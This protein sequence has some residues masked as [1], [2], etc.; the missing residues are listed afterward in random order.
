MAFHPS[1]I[2]RRNFVQRAGLLV[3]ALGLSGTV[4]S[5]IMDSITK[6]AARK[7]GSEA[8][9]QSASRAKFFVEICF[10]A[11]F[12][13]NSLFPS[14]GH[15]ATAGARS[16]RLNFYS[17]AAN[18]KSIDR[19]GR[20]V[21]I[22]TF[23]GLGGQG[24]DA[25]FNELNLRTDVGVATS[26]S[27]QLQTG[28]H[29][30]S[31]NSRGPTGSSAA[32]AIVHASIAA[33]RPV[34]GIEWNNGAAVT[35]E[36]G[37]SGL[38]ALSRVQNRTQFQSLFRELPMYFTKDELKLIV[39][40]F[41][42]EGKVMAGQE[43]ALQRIDQLWRSTQD[44][45]SGVY[46][47]ADAVVV[48]STAGRNQSTLSLLQAIDQRYTQVTGA[49][50]RFAAAGVLNNGLGGTNLAQ[51]LASAA[52]AFS[53]GASSTFTVACESGDWHGDINQL[54][55][56]GGKQGRWNLVLGN[57]LAGL[58]EAANALPDPDEPSKTVLDGL[59]ISLT[60][61][62]T[63]TPLRNGANSGDDNG[64]GGR[65]AFTYIGK[66]VRNGAYG[67]IDHTNGQVI[68]FNIT[69]GQV[70]GAAPTEM[71]MYRTSLKLIGA[72]SMAAGFGVTQMPVDA[73]IKP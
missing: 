61:E 11:G 21:F 8:L 15:A 68:G 4:Q 19:D 32:P 7:W 65:A 3:S 53:A 40:T 45:R 29:T 47:D 16:P 46:N 33:G 9:A 1:Q 60:S 44:P 30:G 25:L 12:Q 20:D 52:A 22:A 37:T 70:G 18:V 71:Q 56:Q 51:A 17:S 41:D 28:Q 24:G 27:V 31:F 36:R 55:D 67:N 38:P 43:G 34:Q 48:N 42:A 2:T 62:F 69:N 49:G 50:S 63:R 13:N 10:R 58:I 14:A 26:E 54:D 5:G 6:K 66:M 64:D 35:N 57:S 72:D 23:P 39:G 73:L 59:L